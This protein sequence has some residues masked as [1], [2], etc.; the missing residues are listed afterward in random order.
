M[1]TPFSGCLELEHFETCM[2]L[3]IV[4]VMAQLHGQ[5]AVSLWLGVQPDPGPLGRSI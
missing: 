4:Q 5:A 3:G 2:T 1:R